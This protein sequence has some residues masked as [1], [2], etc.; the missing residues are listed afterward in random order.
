MCGISS[1][2]IN[3][4]PQHICQ[5][6]STNPSKW[7]NFGGKRST[8]IQTFPSLDSNMHFAGTSSIFVTHLFVK[9]KELVNEN[10]C[11]WTFPYNKAM[12]QTHPRLFIYTVFLHPHCTLWHIFS[13]R[14]SLMATFEVV[15]NIMLFFFRTARAAAKSSRLRGSFRS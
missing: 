14:H 10:P 15:N 4:K 7:L 12:N 2:N 5:Y 11:Q 8:N 6:T 3:S 9:R 1:P 13:P